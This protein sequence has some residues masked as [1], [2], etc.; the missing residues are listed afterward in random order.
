MAASYSDSVARKIRSNFDSRLKVT[1]LRDGGL[2][3]V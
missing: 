3:D 1:I 2:E